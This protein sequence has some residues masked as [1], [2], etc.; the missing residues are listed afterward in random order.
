MPFKYDVSQCY[1]IPKM[2]RRVTNWRAYEAGLRRLGGLTF[3]LEEA[4][5]SGWS[6]PGRMT[7][8]G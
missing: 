5:L 6:A 7:R 2:R 3:W 1:R 4:A 8:S